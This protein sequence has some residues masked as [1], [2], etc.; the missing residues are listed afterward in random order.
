MLIPSLDTKADRHNQKGWNMKRRDFLKVTG[1]GAAGAAT[2]A[3]PAIAQGL[4]EI[5]WRMPTSWPKSL[6]T[7]YGGAELMA[8]MVGEATD[9]KFQIQTFAGGEIVPGLQVLDA[10]QNGTVEIGHTAS[11]YY[12]GKDP[13]FTFGSAVPF[14]PNM[15]LNQAWYMLGGGRDLLNE[16]YK[17]YNV[18]SLLAGN[19]GA[20]MGGWYRKEIKTPED[21]KGLK[22][23]IGGFA[24]RALQKLGVVPQQIAGGD[25]YPALE[26][27]TIDAAEW[28]GPYDDEKLG[29]AKV[30]PNYYYPGWWEGGPMLL[31]FVNLDKWNALPKYYQ[32]VLEQAGHYANNWMMAKYDQA[33]PPALRKLIAAGAKLRPF[34][35]PV[36]EACYKAAKELHSEVAA[37]NADFKKVYESLTSFSNN[38]YSW[39]QVAELGY[40]GFM[41]RHSQ[42]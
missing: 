40:D 29:F 26:K 36:M 12:F 41:A 10:V 4:P 13:T 20:Q 11:Y 28:V 25:I 34:P 38:G 27:G 2:I 5:K 1:L 33:N 19:T 3:A 23:R 42:G 21:L 14:G 32:S 17:K 9:N 37:N 6:D 18:T 22:L 15:R 30:A 16:F 7:L 31:A 8:K 24:G 35:A 39:F